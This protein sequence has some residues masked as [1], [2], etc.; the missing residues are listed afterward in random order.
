MGRNEMI[1]YLREL[2]I[3]EHNSIKIELD[4]LDKAKLVNENGLNMIE[5][6]HGSTF[7]I[8]EL[9][10]DEIEILYFNH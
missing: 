8:D 9:S 6:E 4:N 7:S 1:Q 5:N 2:K 3:T 10:D